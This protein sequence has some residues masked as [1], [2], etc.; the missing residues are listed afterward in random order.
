MPKLSEAAIWSK[1]PDHLSQDGRDDPARARSPKRTGKRAT[2]HC[3]STEYALR[4]KEC[5]FDMVTVSNDVTLTAGAAAASVQTFL[6]GQAEL[7]GGS[8]QKRLTR[9]SALTQMRC[10][11]AVTRGGKGL[12]TT[13]SHLLK[14]LQDKEAQAVRLSPKRHGAPEPFRNTRRAR[15]PRQLVSK[16]QVQIQD[17]HRMGWSLTET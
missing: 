8:Y 14:E 9:F 11:S 6:S 12:E 2:L 3:G 16:I 17:G 10:V 4:G 13:H 15:Q 1:I 7:S 5:G